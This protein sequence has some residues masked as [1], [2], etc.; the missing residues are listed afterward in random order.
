L[1]RPILT[2]D[3]VGHALRGRWLVRDV[4]LSLHPG[5]LTVVIGPNGAGK[6]T[7]MRL[8]TGEIAP[9]AGAIHLDGAPLVSLPAWRLACRRAV[10]V[11][12]A[13]LAFPFTAHE[14]A[15]LGASGVGRALTAVA[16]SDLVTR[17]LEKADVAHLAGRSYQTLSGG[18]QQRVQFA[19]ALAQLEAG[20]SVADRRI[21]F[22]DEPVSS[23]DLKHQLA[24][25]DAARALAESGATGVLAVLHDINLA[26]A[27]ADHLVVMHEGRLAAQGEPERIITDELLEAVFGVALKL[28]RTPPEGEPFLLPQTHRR[29]GQGR[30][31]GQSAA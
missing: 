28:R 24:L 9:S 11:Q 7:L 18:E 6:S 8:L 13:R 2:A 30:G 16:V 15:A 29:Q 3:R 27:Y 20:R 31:Q 12:A 17:S 1:S 21:L 14:V 19:R 23:L 4:S 26:L 10:M 5:R 22:L 25:L